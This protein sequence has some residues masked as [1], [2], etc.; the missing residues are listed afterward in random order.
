MSIFLYRHSGLLKSVLVCTMRYCL[1][2]SSC[3]D[4]NYVFWIMQGVVMAHNIKAIGSFEIAVILPCYN[5]EAAI[6]QTIQEFQKALPSAKIYVFDNNSTDST[7][8]VAEGAGAI[9]RQEYYQG[10]GNVVRRMFADVEAD[11]YIMADGDATYDA[12]AA[13]K[14]V[15]RLISDNLDMVNGARQHTDAEAY[16]SGHRFGNWML[17]KLVQLAFSRQFED[18]L[19]GYRVFSRRYVKSFPAKSGGFEIETELTVHA[20][21]LRMPTAE[22][23]TEYKTRPENSTSK[24]STYA[25]GFRILRMIGFLVK[26]EKP[27]QVFSTLALVIAVPSAIIF[28]SV[29]GEFFDTGKVARFPS[30]FVALSGFIISGGSMMCALILDTISRGRRESRHMRYLQ[31]PSPDQ[32]ALGDDT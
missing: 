19:S 32:S 15:Q 12:A 2:L 17:T 14:M 7:A 4:T 10:K 8:K 28:A 29:L 13:P 5:E 27:L 11:I 31:F 26:E 16:R 9:V 22:V 24:L 6:G 30:L 23:M 1:D 21:E 3:A 25:D 18:M 20:L